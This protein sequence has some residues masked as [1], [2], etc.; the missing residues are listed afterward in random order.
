MMGRKL[1]TT[2]PTFPEKLKPEWIDHDNVF[3]RDQIHKEHYKSYYDQRHNAH[4]LSEL[5]PEDSVRIKTE[6]K[7]VAYSGDR[8]EGRFQNSIV[9]CRDS[10]GYLWQESSTSLED[11]GIFIFYN[12]HGS[13]ST[14]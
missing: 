12:L 11:R 8:T 1:H 2:V 4:H 13:S 9:S 7:I 6:G 5:K 14:C 3:L 10:E